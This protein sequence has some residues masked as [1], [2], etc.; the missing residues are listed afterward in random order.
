MC[1]L[2][3]AGGVTCPLCAL[4]S[5]SRLRHSAPENTAHQT[6]DSV[7]FLFE[8][9]AS[10]CVAQPRFGRLQLTSIASPAKLRSRSRVDT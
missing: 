3:K 7:A 2:A 9:A 1:Y 6:L 4:L 10:F 5:E 8:A